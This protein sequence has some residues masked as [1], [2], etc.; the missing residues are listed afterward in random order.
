MTEVRFPTPD[1]LKSRL[2]NEYAEGEALELVNRGHFVY[3][4]LPKIKL[5]RFNRFVTDN[6][7][8]KA[9]QIEEMISVNI[10]INPPEKIPLLVNFLEGINADFTVSAYIKLSKKEFDALIE[11]LSK[12]GFEEM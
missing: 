11:F 5:P 8:A 9:E 2:L 4:E 1:E 6:E 12:N 10:P 7:I 3:V